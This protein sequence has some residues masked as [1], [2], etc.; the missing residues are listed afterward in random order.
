MKG[1]LSVAALAMAATAGPAAAQQMRIV[2][3]PEI[4]V[5]A[6]VGAGG[7]IYSYARLY[8]ID[9]ARIDVDTRAGNWWNRQALP[10]GTELVPVR[11]AHGNP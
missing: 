5:E 9:G 11:V 2:S 1:F 8:S 6:E 3:S 4:G 7:E 10:A